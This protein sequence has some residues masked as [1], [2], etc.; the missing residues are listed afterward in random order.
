[1]KTKAI[2]EERYSLSIKYLLQIGTEIRPNHEMFWVSGSIF[3][4]KTDLFLRALFHGH[5]RGHRW[6]TGSSLL[7]ISLDHCKT[8]FVQNDFF[9]QDVAIYL[10]R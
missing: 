3:I 4:C 8:I 2:M 5:Y 10:S 1:M 7:W 6:M 9:Q